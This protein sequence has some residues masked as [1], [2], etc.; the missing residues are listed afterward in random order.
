MQTKSR[1]KEGS[2]PEGIWLKSNGR[3][4]WDLRKRL[5]DGRTWRKSSDHDSL[6]KAIA[7]RNQAL[8]D[9][10]RILK[11]LEP[12]YGDN[13]TVEKWCLHCL[14]VVMPTIGSRRGRAYK[15]T[16]LRGYA[17]LANCYI[18][19]HLG[20][21]RLKHL[22]VTH[23]DHF[24]SK[25]PTNDLKIA[26]KNFLSRIMG[27]A[28][29]REKIAV[30]SNPCK[31]IKINRP[32]TK[33]TKGLVV[34]HYLKDQSHSQRLIKVETQIP[35]GKLIVRKRILSFE[36]EEA[37]LT[38]VS[39]HPLYNL[40]LTPI[41]LGLRAGLR[42][43]EAIGLEWSNVHLDEKLIRIEQQANYVSGQ[44]V[45]ISDPK[46][47]AG[48]RPI[49][50]C[51]SLF[52]HLTLLKQTARDEF[53]CT[54]SDGC[55]LEQSRYSERLRRIMYESGLGH[56]VEGSS[57]VRQPSHHDLRR[58]CLS[59]LANGVHSSLTRTQPAPVHIL[60]RF[61]GHEDP[62]TLLDYYVASDDKLLTE[63]VADM[64]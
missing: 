12:V 55:R 13:T 18:L 17:Q 16:T 63:I 25:L 50:L 22:S 51:R 27:L 53:V 20:D 15:A 9:Y 52:D 7:A 59:R 14:N 21:I 32:K 23:L 1:K 19:P 30:G 33:R 57:F 31:K 5:S 42:I 29:E 3:Y 34:R 39:N 46:S 61:A 10:E 56:R 40:Y 4:Q 26:N 2:I 36:E 58:T 48:F 44:G 37:L 45:V 54:S 11:G 62:K 49:P 64:P 28:E 60:A 43:S 8:R 47:M 6:P 24:M 41:L 35:D 38:F